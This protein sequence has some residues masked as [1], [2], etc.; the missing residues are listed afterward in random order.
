MKMIKFA[1][2]VKYA[3]Q[4]IIYAKI[5]FVIEILNLKIYFYLMIILKLVILVE[6]NLLKIKVKALI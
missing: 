4:L 3:Q 5:I 2:C 6:Q 1:I